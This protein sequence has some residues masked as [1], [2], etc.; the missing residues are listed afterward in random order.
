MIPAALPRPPGRR[1]GNLGLVLV[2]LA[3]AACGPKALPEVSATWLDGSPFK[4][5]DLHGRAVWVEF[6]APWDA[7][8]LQRLQDVVDLH[9]RH[10]EWRT[11]LVSVAV[12]G[13]A[14]E[15]KEALARVPGLAFPVVMDTG[16]LSQALG[17]EMVPATVWVGPDG[18]YRVIRQGYVEPS[19]L[20][21]D[22][23]PLLRS[24][25]P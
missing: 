11:R 12:S 6:W 17:V 4:T 7:A 14:A 8:S 20:E 3:L 22:L 23:Q 1:L 24:A 21:Q 25:A 10:P 5:S 19:R 9:K 16:P 18:S 13:T 2:L 15:V